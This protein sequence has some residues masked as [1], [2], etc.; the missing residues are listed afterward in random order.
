MSRLIPLFLALLGLVSAR[1]QVSELGIT[2][3]ATYYI[4][5]L[6]PYRHYPKDTKLAYGVLYRYNFSDRY[7]LRLQALTGTLQAYDERSS[8]SLQLMRNLHFRTRLLEFSGLF[9]VNFRKYR[10]K[11]KDSKRWTPFVFAGLA[12]FRAAPKAELN[13]EWYDLQPLGTEGQGTT[14]RSGSDVYD[15]D[16]V[17]IPFGAGFKWN[18]GRLDFQVEWGLRRT[19]TDYIDDVSGTYVDRDQLALENGPLA[20]TLADRGVLAQQPVYTNTGRSRGDSDTRDWYQY[21]GLSITYVISRFSDC[22]EQ[23]NW[24]R[25]RR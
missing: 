7:A 22:E 6:N 21:T 23:Y 5:D 11:D 9:E 1:A 3:G 24:M 12:Y 19:Y 25:K 20:A 16:N 15:V 13:G 4:G 18:V 2:G 17:C 10:S 8:D 14:A